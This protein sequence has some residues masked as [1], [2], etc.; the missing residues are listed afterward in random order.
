MNVTAT[1]SLP[2]TF[3]TLWDRRWLILSCGLLGA[4]LAFALSLVLPAQYQAE[5]NLV[6]RSQALTAPD[7]DAAFNAAAV[8]QA[9]VTTELEVLTSRGLLA[10]V[11]ERVNIPPQLLDE[12]SLMGAVTTS[13]RFAA[14]LAG[15]AALTWVDQ[16]LAEISSIRLDQPEL[17]FRPTNLSAVI[18]RAVSGLS[19]LTETNKVKVEIR[20][21]EQPPTVPGDP[22]R[23]AEASYGL[24]AIAIGRSQP[25]GRLE[26]V[27]A[28]RPGAA[29]V[30]I[31]PDFT[32][33]AGQAPPAESRSQTR[34][35]RRNL[36][37]IHE[38]L[39]LTRARRIIKAHGGKLQMETHGK[40][41][42]SWTVILPTV[43]NRSANG[44]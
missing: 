30:E 28:P 23:L 9:V 6:V 3:H 15:S 18:Q 21:R 8:N 14:S 38:A 2:G 11:A 4:V 44:S 37:D 25:A 42:P 19:W 10:R 32:A 20:T 35:T 27:I 31:H 33:P 34:S 26:I 24:I 13:V 36:S 43:A 41:G 5:G 29:T 40:R 12:W 7:N 22:A 16:R 17:E 39:L 1:L